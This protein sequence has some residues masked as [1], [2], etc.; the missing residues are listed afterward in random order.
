MTRK[1]LYV[2]AAAWVP[3]LQSG[4]PTRT[5]ILSRPLTNRKKLSRGYISLAKNASTTSRCM[6]L[7]RSELGKA[8]LPNG[9]SSISPMR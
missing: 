9:A 5:L 1:I 2:V 6:S 8:Q 7:L 3:G 4:R